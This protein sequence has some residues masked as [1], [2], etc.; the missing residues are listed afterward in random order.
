M[1]GNYSDWFSVE[2]DTGIVKVAKDIRFD[3]EK[4]D[5]FRIKVRATDGAPSS[6]PQSGGAPNSRK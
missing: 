2:P 5:Y 6:R 1:P 4:D 3:R